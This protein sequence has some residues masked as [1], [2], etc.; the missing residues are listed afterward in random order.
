VSALN[1]D[2]RREILLAQ[3]R[4]CD[5]EAANCR[6]YQENEEHSQA[7]RAW[8]TMGE[9]D[10]LVA[11]LIYIE[12][13]E[14]LNGERINS[15]DVLTNIALCMTIE[16]ETRSSRHREDE[17][18]RSNLSMAFAKAKPAQAFF[19]AGFYG[20]QGSGK[21]LTGL[22][23]GEY[24]AGLEK[25][26][27]AYVDTEHG[28]DFY[29]TAIPERKIHPAAFDFDAVYTRSIVEVCDEIEAL[30]PTKYGVVVID[31][32][33]HIWEATKAAY[34]GKM[35]SNGAIPVQA[36]AQIKKPYKKLMSLL[37]DGQYHVIISGRQGVV[38]E[39]DEEN[40]PKVV[41]AKMKAEGE[42]P[43]EPN[44]LFQFRPEWTEEKVQRIA[45]FVEKDRSGILQGKT[46]YE[47]KPTDI[48][49][50]LRYLSAGEQARFGNSES[51]AERDAAALE[52]EE[53]RAKEERRALFEQIKAALLSAQNIAE[54]KTAWSLTNGKRTKLGEE[55]ISKLETIKNTQRTTFVE[56]A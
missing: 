55:F 3:I 11:R 1:R 44:F 4:R 52:L 20:I 17:T 8:A 13:L 39:E 26:R 34:K 48:D 19:K 21:S 28:T 35:L 23:F 27:I 43:Y 53:D 9:V 22:L 40:Q 49:P 32:I 42:T 7:D 41:G 14:I 50:I 38:M 37:L 51:T 56:A 33:T 15:S 24:L 6:K 46:L 12:E 25:K 30:D 16:E 18:Q 31:S 10:W 29:A 45:A 47:P 54:L 2:H 5:I 36:W